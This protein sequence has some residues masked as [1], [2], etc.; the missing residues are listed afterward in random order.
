MSSKREGS[1]ELS[2][3][4][5]IAGG[6]HIRRHKSMST[7]SVTRFV[8]YGAVGFG[9]GWAIAGFLTSGFLAI[10]NP[11]FQ[12]PPWWV[13][14]PPQ[15]AYFLGGALGGAALGAAKGTWKRVVTLALAGAVGFGVGSILFFVV[16]FLF[17]FPLVSVGMGA[18]GG[19][20][21]GLALADWRGVVL[22]G[23]AGMVG[24]GVGEAI[25]IALGMPP[26]AFDWEQP[27]LWQML[28]V[29]VQG[30]V[31]IIGGASLGAALGYLE[32]REPVRERSPR[33]R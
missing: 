11:M 12:T 19:I 28:F 33:V 4:N 3:I 16:A 5:R 8:L 29:L 2:V 30:M 24:F 26:F 1:R 13:E 6:V 22:L 15:M 27:P 18:L 10:T 7:R 23:L 25:A 9:I 31:G 32:R 21:L 17:G 14:W 20:L